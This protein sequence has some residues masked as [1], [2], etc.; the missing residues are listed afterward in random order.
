MI[1]AFDSVSRHAAGPAETAAV[2]HH[3]RWMARS[4]RGEG[5]VNHSP[6]RHFSTVHPR[7]HLHATP[8]GCTQPVSPSRSSSFARRPTSVARRNGHY[9]L[10]YLHSFTSYSYSTCVL[11]H[12]VL[13]CIRIELLAAHDWEQVETLF[14]PMKHPGLRRM[15]PDDSYT[16]WWC[17]LF[18]MFSSRAHTPTTVFLPPER[19]VQGHAQLARLPRHR[20]GLAP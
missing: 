9:S 16:S 14:R 17:P 20:P 19:R 18:S 6:G 1:Q 2:I 13:Y 3:H 11:P 7:N 15:K 5:L 12:R 8:S 4:G 10:L